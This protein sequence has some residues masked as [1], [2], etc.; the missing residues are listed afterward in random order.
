MGSSKSD[1]SQLVAVT[2][3]PANEC[4]SRDEKKVIKAMSFKVKWCQSLCAASLCG[5]L[6]EFFCG[7]ALVA[8]ALLHSLEQ[9]PVFVAHHIF[10]NLGKLL[11]LLQLICQ[12]F[13]ALSYDIVIFSLFVYCLGFLGLD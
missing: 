1:A 13:P 10:G 8:D 4:G 11:L 3:M 9:F 12:L 7:C 2:V 6:L 5:L